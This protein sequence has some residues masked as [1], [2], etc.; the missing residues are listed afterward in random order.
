MIYHYIVFDPK[1][2]RNI[3]YKSLYKL[4]FVNNLQRQN[5]K[6]FLQK[7]Q[8]IYKKVFKNQLGLH[9]PFRDALLENHRSVVKK[10]P[11]YIF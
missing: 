1:L 7:V 11:G 10:M 4:I 5:C 8:K 6:N 2:T 3:L 9:W